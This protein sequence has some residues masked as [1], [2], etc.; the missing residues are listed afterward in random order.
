MPHPE[1]WL[2]VTPAGLWCE[3][4][5]FFVDPTRAVARAV[6]TH[7]HAD[8]ARPGHEAVLATAETLAL[9]RARLGEGRAGRR[10]QPLRPGE[11]VVQNGVRLWLRPAGH[12]LGS[13]QVCLEWRG[14]RVVVSGDYKRA[15]DP[16]CAPFEAER[17][18]VFVT[19]A[20]FGLPVFRHPEPEREIARLLASVALFPERTHLV[21][22]YALGKCQRLIALLRRAGWQA[23]IWLH[24]T[25]L[26]ACRTYE[27]LGVPLGDLRPVTAARRA[28]LRGAIVLAPPG[29][30]AERW[31]ER[32]SDPVIA[33]ASGWMRVRHHARARG[34][35]LPLVVSDHADWDELNATIDETGAPEVWIMHGRDDALAHA[36]GRRGIRGRALHRVGRGAGEADA[37]PGPAEDAAA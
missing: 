3:P 32:L 37:A 11:V 16:T 27:A 5:D 15:P 13:A 2:R 12:V 33:L 24:E 36:L 30:A 6:I 19:E 22:C 7:A 26:A 8:H 10:Q 4:G 23:P 31:A 34:V 21:G 17:C 9:M 28:A 14:S 29:A 25:L 1:T 20:T 35:E 18:D